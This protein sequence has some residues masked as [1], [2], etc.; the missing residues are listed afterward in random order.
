MWSLWASL[1]VLVALDVRRSSSA[2]V[3][4]TWVG[5]GLQLLGSELWEVDRGWGSVSDWKVIV[6]PVCPGSPFHN[7]QFRW[8]SVMADRDS[9]GNYNQKKEIGGICLQV[10]SVVCVAFSTGLWYFIYAAFMSFSNWFQ[11]LTVY[12]CRC[13]AFSHVSAEV[14]F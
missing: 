6:E 2:E 7:L 10:L 9:S 13:F 11:G 14:W 12:C 8:D 1:W 4:G 3:N 5:G